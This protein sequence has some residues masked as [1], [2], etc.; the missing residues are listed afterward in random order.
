MPLTTIIVASSGPSLRAS[1]TERAYSLS[2][3]MIDSEGAQI[4]ARYV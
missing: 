1:G 4:A 2:S 3:T